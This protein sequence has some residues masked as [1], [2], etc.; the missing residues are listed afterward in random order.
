[1]L[2]S[3]GVVV[4]VDDVRTCLDLLVP[5][6]ATGNMPETENNITMGLLELW[7]E[8]L[9]KKAKWSRQSWESLGT[10]EKASLLVSNN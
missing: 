4:T 2:T 10:K 5:V 1:M 3:R 6:L 7:L 8:E 9:K